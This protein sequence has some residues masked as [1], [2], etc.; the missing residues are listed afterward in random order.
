MSSPHSTARE[1]AHAYKVVIPAA[2]LGTRFLPATKAIPKELLPIVDTPALQY[3]VEEAVDAGLKQVLVIVGRGKEAIIDH[4]DHAPELEAALEKKGDSDR[5]KSVQRSAELA[6]VHYIR[7]GEPRGLGHAVNCAAPYVGQEV[8]AVMLGDDLIDARDDL[9]GPMLEVQQAFGGCVVAL[10]EVPHDQVSMYGCAAVE[11]VQAPAISAP[12]S[13]GDVVRITD[14]VE[15]PTPEDAPSNLA[16]IGRYVLSPEIFDALDRTPPGR[17]GEVQ[18]TDAMKLLASEGHPIHGVVFTGRRYD[19]GDRGDYLRAVVR[20]AAE[21]EDLGPSFV[22]WLGEFL[23][24]FQ[25]E[26]SVSS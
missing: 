1:R 22:E 3:I 18:L 13:I 14:L 6:D 21:R 16:I 19:T 8:F 20:L 15:K 10:M 17:G 4:F 12:R 9:L 7:Q 25:T 24:E 2:G 26:R 5:L 23:H 11:A